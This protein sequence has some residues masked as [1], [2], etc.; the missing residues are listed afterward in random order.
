MTTT[1]PTT[2]VKKVLYTQQRFLFMTTDPVHIGTGGYR[3]SRVDMT[4]VREPGTNLPKIPGTSLAGAAR[5]YAAMRYGKLDVAGQQ[6]VFNENRKHFKKEEIKCPI[7]YTFGTA[8]DNSEH[9][10]NGSSGR[11]NRAGTVSISDAHILFFP[12]SSMAGHV[13]VSTHERI[14]EA[15]GEQSVELPDGNIK[16]T[17]DDVVTSMEGSPS[18]RGN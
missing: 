14:K 7:I 8:T 15:W 9:G 17:D 4:I 16:P 6:K 10:Q 2:K 12:V 13:W 18:L 3:L 11:I 5:S 1:D